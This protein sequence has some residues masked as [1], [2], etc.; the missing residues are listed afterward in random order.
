MAK[1]ISKNGSLFLTEEMIE[2][3][4]PA[5]KGFYT[6]LIKKIEHAHTYPII[7]IRT[8]Y[9]NM[10]MHE[11]GGFLHWAPSFEVTLPWKQ[12]NFYNLAIH[13]Y[14]ISGQLERLINKILENE[15]GLEGVIASLTL[16]E[17][18]C[19]KAKY[20]DTFLGSIK[21]LLNFMNKLNDEHIDITTL[22]A[23][24]KYI[25]FIDFLFTGNLSTDFN[26]T[27]VST[28]YHQ[29]NGNVIDLLATAKSEEAII[30]MLEERLSPSNYQRPDPTKVVSE[31][32]ISVA[33]KT[34]GDF[35]NTPMTNA[36]I[37]VL[38]GALTLF[39]PDASAGAGYS[40]MREEMLKARLAARYKQGFAKRCENPFDKIIT[41]TD[42]YN[43]IKANPLTA[44][45]IDIT[46]LIVINLIKTTLSGKVDADGDPYIRVPHLWKFNNGKKVVDVIGMT[47]FQPVTHL[48]QFKLDK[49]MNVYMG[50]KNAVDKGTGNC[51]FPGFLTP[52]F[53]RV[54]GTVF[55]KMNT[56]TK[57]NIPEE[58][59]FCGVGTSV[60]DSTGKFYSPLTFKING[61]VKTIN[62]F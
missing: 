1:Y 59:Y 58:P 14:I 62:A 24:S 21:W 36:E 15:G 53:T 38:E 43:Y 8:I 26:H 46:S 42:L 5:H 17:A 33:E 52:K 34:L 29:A 49:N 35:V 22:D 48:H 11:D 54:L 57:L 25:L 20:G 56:M 32:Q 4:D 37:S 23:K 18:C 50:I 12:S 3:V 47:G 13:R 30:K 41:F 2:D 45:E 16:M 31:Q 28:N 7:N 19:H 51:C 61:H 40:A 60:V 10:I 39:P 6:E 9:E 27:T 44:L 55:E